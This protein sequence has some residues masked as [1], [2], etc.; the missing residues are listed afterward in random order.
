MVRPADSADPI[1]CVRMS[2]VGTGFQ[3]RAYMLH[4]GQPT[5]HVV[6]EGKAGRS[7]AEVYRIVDDEHLA[8]IESCRSAI[9]TAK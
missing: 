4:A 9:T 5:G 7:G 8:G 6:G 2:G 1:A 3:Q